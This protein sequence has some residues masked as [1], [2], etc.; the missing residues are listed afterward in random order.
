MTHLRSKRLPNRGGTP[1]AVAPAA[2][3]GPGT[4]G[5]AHTAAPVRGEPD[6]VARALVRNTEPPAA[7]TSSPWTDMSGSS[8]RDARFAEHRTTGPAAALTADRPWPGDARARAHTV[9]AHPAGTDG[10]APC[11]RS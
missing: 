10:R 1:A 2:S 6:A 3:P 11:A 4:A 5:E 7:V 9:A 8:R